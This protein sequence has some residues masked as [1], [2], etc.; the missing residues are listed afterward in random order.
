[1]V[2]SLKCGSFNVAC[3]VQLQRVLVMIAGWRCAMHF[4]TAPALDSEAN[5]DAGIRN[6][7]FGLRL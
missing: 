5:G 4:S 1:M 7:G 2:H 3:D 6:S